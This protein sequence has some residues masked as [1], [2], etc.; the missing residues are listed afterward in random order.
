M[1]STVQAIMDDALTMLRLMPGRATQQYAAPIIRLSVE[2]AFFQV[3]NSTEHIW[4]GYR[5]RVLG[6]AIVNG[7]MS[8]DLVGLRSIPVAEFRDV[9]R[10]WQED[11]RNP[12]LMR[13]DMEND[14]T[15]TASGTA[16]W[17]EP[18]MDV[19]NRPFKVMPDFDGTV[20]VLVRTR[21]PRPFA[22][23]DVIYMD[24]D[25][26]VYAAVFAHLTG[27]GANP[28]QL[29]ATQTAFL[30]AYRA[31]LREEQQHGVSFDGVSADI[32][33]SWT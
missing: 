33:M 5:K 21:P 28:G 6:V 20:N 16:L 31:A 17:I 27:S 26:L 9:K 19:A 2:Q 1:P 3:F 29:D 7:A 22:L 30:T 11:Y 18:S 8:S 13:S 15:T 23:T 4:S 10:V 24:H 25:M 12:I 32:P 14:F